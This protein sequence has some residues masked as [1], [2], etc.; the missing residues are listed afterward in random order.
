MDTIKQRQSNLELFRIILMLA[1]IAHHYVVNS[2]LADTI[3]SNPTS[4]QSI[5]LLLFG[6][7][8]KTGINCFLMITG[9]FM[10]KSNI[11]LK[12]FLKLLL[13]VEFYKIIFGILFILGGYI[14]V[15]IKSIAK[16]ILPI[17]SINSGFASCFL[18]FFLCIPFLNVLINSLDKKN[19]HNYLYCL[20]PFIQFFRLCESRLRLTM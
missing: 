16:I 9:Y 19:M 12:K 18:L 14:P 5:F 13:E 10:C 17:T 11:T 2:G 7:W 8:G 20:Y 6:A 15:N 4:K 1:I 3:A